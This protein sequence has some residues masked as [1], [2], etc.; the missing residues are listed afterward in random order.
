MLE[1]SDAWKGS[2]SRG[3]AVPECL[4]CAREGG[5]AAWAAANRIPF[6]QGVY[7]GGCL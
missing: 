7:P 5:G 6:L 3:N 2:P 4:L 1:A